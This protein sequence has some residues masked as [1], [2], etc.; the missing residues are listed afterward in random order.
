MKPDRMIL[1][2]NANNGLFNAVTDWS[3]KMFSPQTYQCS[4]CR[5]TFGLTGML[6]PWKNFLLMQPF[7]SDFLHRDEFR[8]RYP[9]LAATP[10]PLILV[11]KDGVAEVLIGAAEIQETG[12][13]ASLIGLVQQRLE[14]WESAPTGVVAPVTSVR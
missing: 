9:H 2:Y 11:E 14:E 10:L 5:Y 12:G 1:V 4:L 7:P 13:V 3:H 6:I 8:P